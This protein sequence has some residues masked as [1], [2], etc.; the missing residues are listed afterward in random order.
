MLRIIF[1]IGFIFLTACGGGG[2]G[3]DSEATATDPNQSFPLVVWHSTQEGTIASFEL[4]GVDS[5]GTRFTGTVLMANRAKVNSTDGV[6]LT[7]REIL[8]NL[9]SNNSSQTLS[10]FS[11]RDPDG[12]L[13]LSYTPSTDINCWPAFLYKLPETVI[14]GDFGSMPAMS[15]EDNSTSES[16]WWISDAGNGRVNLT[17]GLTVKNS[18]GATIST[19]E[20]TF[21]LDQ[22]GAIQAYDIFISLTGQNYTLSMSSK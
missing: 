8:V 22:L 2:G 12:Y 20:E 6:L 3:G 18:T 14:I 13:R 15:C 5:D 1:S 4:E 11:Y 9:S 7:P 19:G 16:S 10:T 17:I 21:L